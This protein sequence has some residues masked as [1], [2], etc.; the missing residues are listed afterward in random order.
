MQRRLTYLLVP[1]ALAAA[2]LL[3]CT[4][5]GGQGET[6]DTVR[7][8]DA[9]DPELAAI[10]EEAQETLGEFFMHLQ[11]KREGEKDF[12]VKVPFTAQA[13]NGINREFVWLKDIYF[14]NGL[15]YGTAAN[16]PFYI[17]GFEEGALASFN[18]EDIS[19][20]MYRRDGK[21]VGGLS[22]KYLIEMTP[23][24]DRSNELTAL[25]NLFEAE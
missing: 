21:I 15:Y 11:R 12:M 25:L 8:V 23:E 14:R 17:E 2:V 10:A 6:R 22:V 3:G 1:V 24:I 16:R 5:R 20:W 13:G 4:G 7:Q 19:D 9:D 18:A